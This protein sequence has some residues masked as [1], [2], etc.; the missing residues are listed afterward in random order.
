MAFLNSSFFVGLTTFLVAITGM[1][2]IW[3]YKKQQKD[4]KMQAARVLL[5]EIRTAEERIEQIRDILLKLL[6]PPGVKIVEVPEFPM[7]FP[8]KSW[9]T[10][11][12]L[13][14]SDF[15][16][17]EFKLISSFYDYGEL[18]EDFARRNNNFFWITTEER[19]RVTQQT[20]AGTIEKAFDKFKNDTEQDIDK[21]Q[22]KYITEHIDFISKK[23]DQFTI[24][25]VPIRTIS[26]IDSY[27]KKIQTITTSSCGIKL[28]RIAK[29]DNL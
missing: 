1:S 29:L 12:S 21:Q 11:S 23:L 9:K 13:F 25:Y 15:D 3:I 27:L 22:N 28:K 14:V 24:P 4:R 20:I 5:M 18:I 7:V 10:Y 6:R 17:D 2:A 19:A 16:H 26:E 8:T